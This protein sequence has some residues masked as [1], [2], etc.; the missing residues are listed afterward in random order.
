MF[1][2]LSS[3]LR[4]IWLAANYTKS[5]VLMLYWEPD[6][7]VSKFIGE[8]AEFVPIIMPPS[9]KE[10]FDSRLSGEERCTKEPNYGPPVG[11][12]GDEAHMIQKLI[13]SNIQ[14]N[15]TVEVAQQSPA[16]QALML[17]KFRELDLEYLFRHWNDNYDTG[18]G[19]REAIW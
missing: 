1:Y 2:N 5:H 12:C 18:Y 11:A 13:V 15:N 10:C 16:Y 7:L 4:Q 3:S 14:D 19:Y 9:T 6:P 17:M 8:D